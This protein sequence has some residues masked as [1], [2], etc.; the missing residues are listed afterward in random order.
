MHVF[1]NFYVAIF[2]H[3]Y[4]IW[5]HQH[6]TISQS[7]FVLQ[8]AEKVAKKNPRELLRQLDR[9]LSERKIR[10]IPDD[11]NVLSKS[12]QPDKVDIFAGVCDLK[13]DEEEEVHLV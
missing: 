6:K 3:I 12:K 5:K 8:E 4:Q 1:N 11:E 2:N 10:I 13:V 9:T 7:G